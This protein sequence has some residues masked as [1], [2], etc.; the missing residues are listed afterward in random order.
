MKVAVKM[1]MCQ[2]EI[3]LLA[4]TAGL[5]VPLHDVVWVRKHDRGRGGR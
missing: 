2:G 5:R 4:N 1:V 3:V